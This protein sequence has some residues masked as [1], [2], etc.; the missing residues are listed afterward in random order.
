MS[1]DGGKLRSYLD[2][3][4]SPEEQAEV[5]MAIKQNSEIKTVLH[6]LASEREQVTQQFDQLAP[7]RTPQAVQALTRFH[8]HATLNK[9]KPMALL[10]ERTMMMFSQGFM[11]QYKPAIIGLVTVVMV[12]IL[13]SF[14]PVRTL[15]ANFLTIFRVQE[16]KI[17]RVDVDRIEDLKNN[18]ELSGLLDQ[19]D[20]D[21]DVVSG[22][23][24]PEEV[25]TVDEAAG[26]VDF[27]VARIG[28]LPED[29]GETNKILVQEE[30]VYSL[31]LDKDLLESIFEAA[32]VEL[33]LPDSLNEQ[34]ITVTKG[35]SVYQQWGT[36]EKPTLSFAQ[37]RSPEIDHPDD[38]DLNAFGVAVL[39]LLGKSKEEA[40]AMGQTID[41]ANTLLLPIPNDDEV[42]ATEVDIN[43]AKG[44]LS[45]KDDKGSGL[46]WQR[47]G[48]TYILG[49]EYGSEQLLSIARSVQ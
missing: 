26:K 37:M 44:V 7:D 31:D 29:A 3:S 33:S 16:V 4:L 30:A 32:G 28:A 18:E 27:S 46:M 49:G 13:F 34:P 40:E 21:P 12:A 38:L 6:Q 2:R 8:S 48:I 25:E 14:A 43:G 1:I 24:D 11:K 5:E 20:Q 35:D 23:G 39:Q 15:A 47:D 45:S 17:V 42:D 36:E 19:L 10:F 41:W 9:N 22:G